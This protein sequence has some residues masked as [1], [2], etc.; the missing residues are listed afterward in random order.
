MVR[1]SAGVFLLLAAASLVSARESRA[2]LKLHGLFGDGMILQRE[3]PC[4]V[5]GT[6]TP[7]DAVSVS[8]AGQTKSTKAGADGRWSLK[9]DPLKAGGP[10]E[11]KVNHLVL[12]DV[13]V[14]EVWLASGGENMEMP[15]KTALIS[16]TE[17]DDNPAAMIRFF[18]VPRRESE[19]PLKD[20]EGTWKSNHS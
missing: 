5:W 10:Y 6:S 4:P 18:V 16:K 17:P 7:G 19:T 12:R 9:L 1:R 13:L 14:G 11:L 20:V 8:I 15:V 3:I 2:E